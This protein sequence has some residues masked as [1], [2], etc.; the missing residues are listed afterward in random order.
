LRAE[1]QLYRDW[2]PAPALRRVLL[3]EV[4][5]AEQIEAATRPRRARS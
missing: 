1:H 3:A 4:A 2:L 5:H